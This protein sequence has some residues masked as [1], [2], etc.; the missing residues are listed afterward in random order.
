MDIHADLPHLNKCK[1]EMEGKSMW[2]WK[3]KVL[4]GLA[5]SEPL[6]EDQHVFV[7]HWSFRLFK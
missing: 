4:E 3:K 2:A 6:A 5:E 1:Q 7:P